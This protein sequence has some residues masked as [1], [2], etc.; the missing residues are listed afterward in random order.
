MAAKFKYKALSNGTLNHPYRF[1]EA[2]EIVESDV[3]IKARWL[4]PLR[5]ANALKPLPLMPNLQF[6]GSAVQHVA[7]PPVAAR[8]AYDAQIKALEEKER[9]QDAAG[10]GEPTLPLINPAEP[11]SEKPQE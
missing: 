3:E 9:Q 11:A 4:L 7:I 2:G 1:V 10:K 8:P 6:A 5:E